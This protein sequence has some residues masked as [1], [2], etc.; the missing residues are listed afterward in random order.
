MERTGNFAVRKASIS[1]GEFIHLNTNWTDQVETGE[2][3]AMEQTIP[4]II[5]VMSQSTLPLELFELIWL[6]SS[7]RNG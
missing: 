7:I 5:N 4:L 2:L 1:L 6:D 3:R